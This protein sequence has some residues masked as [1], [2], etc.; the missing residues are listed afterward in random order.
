M[1][2]IYQQETKGETTLGEI[3]DYVTTEVKKT[4][5]VINGKLQTPNASA[6]Q[7]LGDN[8]RNIKF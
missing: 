7:S 8:W 1:G 5:I 4:S 6:S 2:T 3:A